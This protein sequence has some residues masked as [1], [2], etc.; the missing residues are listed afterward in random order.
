MSIL[1]PE[2]IR[3][4]AVV[5][6]HERT[7]HATQRARLGV[8]IFAGVCPAAAVLGPALELVAHAIN[9]EE[10][11]TEKFERRDVHRGIEG[12][13]L[14]ATLERPGDPLRRSATPAVSILG[15]ACRRRLGG[16]CPG[17]PIANSEML[18]F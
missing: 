15:T 13:R 7:A 3:R 1:A 14:S 10:S 6:A 17:D 16:W 18:K 4:G 5:T 2:V 11:F 9:I 12:V 8:A